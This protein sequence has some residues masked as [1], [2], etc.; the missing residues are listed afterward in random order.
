MIRLSIYQNGVRYSYS[1]AFKGDLGETIKTY[2]T[3]RLI[4]YMLH[5]VELV[6]RC[7]SY[8]RPISKTDPRIYKIRQKNN[9]NVAQK[10]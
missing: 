2:T 7:W 3:T 10:H 5:I 6:N 1:S 9:N 4:Q 8:R